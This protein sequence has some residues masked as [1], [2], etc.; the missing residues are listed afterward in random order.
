MQIFAIDETKINSILLCTF[1]T[2]ERFPTHRLRIC[3]S[4]SQTLG[5][6]QISFVRLRAYATASARGNGPAR[7]V[8]IDLRRIPTLQLR[9][10]ACA[11]LV[12]EG[13]AVEVVVTCLDAICE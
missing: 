6:A 1:C 2:N 13:G 3:F 5:K 11:S 10:G 4:P 8:G 9:T 12:R 7:K